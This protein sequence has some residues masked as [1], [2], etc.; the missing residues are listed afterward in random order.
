MVYMRSEAVGTHEKDLWAS[1]DAYGLVLI[2][3]IEYCGQFSH[4]LP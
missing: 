1:F 2:S 3:Y 4:G